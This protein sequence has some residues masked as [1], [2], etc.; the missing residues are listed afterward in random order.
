MCPPLLGSLC[1]HPLVFGW[2]AILATGPLFFILLMLS[3]RQAPGVPG[4]KRSG[5]DCVARLLLS[6][7][8]SVVWRKRFRCDMSLLLV[9]APD[10]LIRVN[11]R[12]R[13]Y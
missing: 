8:V 12:I 11:N 10:E 2:M 9:V 5:R 7:V 1:L 4:A 13:L 6:A 3:N